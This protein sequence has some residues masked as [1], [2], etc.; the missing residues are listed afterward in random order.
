M[1][2]YDRLMRDL[3]RETQ[4]PESAADVLHDRL[5][6]GELATYAPLPELEG[7]G[8]A[9]QERAEA[10]GRRLAAHPPV[11]VRWRLPAFAGATALLCLVL[12]L[13]P[14]WP[15]P[16]PPDAVPSALSPTQPQLA[17]LLPARTTLVDQALQDDGTTR[18]SSGVVL[19]WQGEGQLHSEGSQTDLVWTAGRVRLEVPPEQGLSVRVRTPD[20][21]AE[22]VGTVF[23]VERGAEG[24]ITAVERG[25]VRVACVGQEPVLV[26][27]GESRA[28]ER[29]RASALLAMSRRLEARGAPIGAIL[30]VLE[31]ALLD[32]SA[33]AAIRQELLFLTAVWLERSGEPVEAAARLRRCL[34][35][36]DGL[37]APDARQMLARLSD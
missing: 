5:Q 23:A 31:T 18:L 26:R 15:E 20:G 11:R 22:V 4:A 32:D 37:R 7:L 28:C 8:G 6:R 27:A 2:S 13:A 36:G 10:L 1:S 35:L 14:S 34:E 24:T 25:A 3:A 12:W 33:P 30:Q 19:T 29:R 9:S 16:P 21:H 17:A